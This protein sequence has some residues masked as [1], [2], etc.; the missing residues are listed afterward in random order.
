MVLEWKECTGYL[1]CDPKSDVRKVANKTSR[2]GEPIWCFGPAECNLVKSTG[3]EK[4]VIMKP[5]D[6]SGPVLLAMA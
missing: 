3:G 4:M 6:L 2:R 5:E 1:V